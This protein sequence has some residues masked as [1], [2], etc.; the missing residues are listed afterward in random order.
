MKYRILA[1][2]NSSDTYLDSEQFDTVDEAVKY[3]IGMMWGSDFYII[4]I[5]DW[6]VKET[7]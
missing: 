4:Q 5:I 6:G 7:K 1:R 2:P 3:A